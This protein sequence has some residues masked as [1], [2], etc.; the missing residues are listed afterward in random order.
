VAP[1]KPAADAILVDTT[2]KSLD[3]VVD[4]LMSHVLRRRPA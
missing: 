4:E 2:G 3:Q 1:L